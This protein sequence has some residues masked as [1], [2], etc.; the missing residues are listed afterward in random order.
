MEAF[1]PFPTSHTF[2]LSLLFLLFLTILLTLLSL[3]FLQFQI[4]LHFLSGL[5]KGFQENISHQGLGTL[6]NTTHSG[7]TARPQGSPCLILVGKGSGIGVLLMNKK[8]NKKNMILEVQSFPKYLIPWRSEWSISHIPQKN[9]STLPQ[10]GQGCWGSVLSVP[11]QSLIRRFRICLKKLLG[12][13]DKLSMWQLVF[14]LC[15]HLISNKNNNKP[16]ECL[17]VVADPLYH[18]HR[19]K[20]GSP[21]DLRPFQLQLTLQAKSTLSEKLLLVQE[22]TQEPTFNQTLFVQT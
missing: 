1:K 9:T 14:A 4:I 11:F 15:H 18:G 2:V 21:N 20:T 17:M 16:K 6:N 5:F 13:Q 22:N 8:K 7:P 3:L 10:G 19:K 12:V